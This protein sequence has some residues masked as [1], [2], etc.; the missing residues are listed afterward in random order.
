MLILTLHDG[1]DYIQIGDDVRIYVAPQSSDAYYKSIRI[2]IEAPKHINI[3]RR[4][5]IE[6]GQ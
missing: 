1:D 2:K 6:R 3:K 5:V 4:K